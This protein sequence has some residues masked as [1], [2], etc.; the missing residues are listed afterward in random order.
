MRTDRTYPVGFMDV[1]DIP[2]T[3]GCT[4]CFGWLCWQLKCDMGWI[5][6]LLCTQCRCCAA[7]SV[8]LA[9]CGSSPSVAASWWLLR[10]RVEQ[11]MG[12]RRPSISMGAAAARHSG[13]HG[14][15]QPDGAA[16]R[17]R[18]PPWSWAALLMIAW[19]KRARPSSLATSSGCAQ[20]HRSAGGMQS[21]RLPAVRNS[22][23]STAGS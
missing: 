13:Q 21:P 16:A 20:Q 22:A 17:W 10:G 8:C 6:L 18:Q 3:G 14:T 19:A 7:W 11:P 4:G 12:W 9:A 2:K 15:P 1:V 23:S 5:L